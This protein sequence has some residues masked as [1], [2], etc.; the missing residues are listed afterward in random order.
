[1]IPAP[2]HMIATDIKLKGRQ[3]Q[4]HRTL[5][6]LISYSSQSRQYRS[7]SSSPDRLLGLFSRDREF[8][9]NGS[10]CNLS[11]AWCYCCCSN[12]SR[13]RSSDI[14]IR[15]RR[16]CWCSGHADEGH[17]TIHRRQSE[18]ECQIGNQVQRIC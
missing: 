14:H 11:G 8:F 2:V 13:S 15:S 7:R 9:R 12:A 18:C 6:H 10:A 4:A 16:T 1:M 3:D 5:G 17:A